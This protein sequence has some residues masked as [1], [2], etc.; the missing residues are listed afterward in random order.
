VFNTLF[1]ET[2]SADRLSSDIELLNSAYF[3]PNGEDLQFGDPGDTLRIDLTY[4]DASFGNELGYM[5]GESYS[6]LIDASHIE[7]HQ[8]NQHGNTFTVPE[9]FMFADTVSV[10]GDP[11]QRWYADAERNPLGQKDHFLAFAIDDQ[12]LLDNYYSMY[13]VEYSAGLDDVWLIAFED[14]NL[15]DAD[16][17]DLVAVVSRPSELNSTPVPTP[18]PAAVWLLGSGILG[19]AG[20]RKRRG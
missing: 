4:R 11:M 19:I 2:E 14:L 9:N 7:N 18:L 1:Y 13:G 17:T 5:S 16:Y 20:L 6:T 8:I 15:G 12:T 3:L 10:Y